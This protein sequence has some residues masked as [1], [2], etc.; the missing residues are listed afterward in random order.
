MESE[1]YVYTYVYVVQ[2][3][4]GTYTFVFWMYVPLE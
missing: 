2:S 4:I 3:R 1:G